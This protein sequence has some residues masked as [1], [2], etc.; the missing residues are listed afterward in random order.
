VTLKE[1]E[2]EQKDIEK[3]IVK[4][5]KVVAKEKAAKAKK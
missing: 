4:A 1:F 3:D 5:E 2:S